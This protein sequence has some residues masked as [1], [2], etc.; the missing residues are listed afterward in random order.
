MQQSRFGGLARLIGL[1]AAALIVMATIALVHVGLTAS[2]EADTQAARSEKALFETFLRG[3]FHLMARDQLSLAQWDKSVEN[4]VLHFNRRYLRTEVFEPLWYD[5]AASFN[6]VVAADGTVVASAKRD[7]VTFATDRHRLDGDAARLRDQAVTLFFA[8]RVAVDGGFRRR[9]VT[10]TEVGEIAAAGFVEIDG[11][12]H[13]AVAMAI[14][15]DDGSVKLPD[16]PP[17]VLLSARPLDRDLVAEFAK[18]LGFRDLAFVAAADAPPTGWVARTGDGRSVGA[19]TW[20]ADTPGARIWRLIVPLI[21]GAVAVLGAAA[22]LVARQIGGLSRRLEASEAHN[23][24]VARHD[25]L[26]GLA[27]RREIEE[28]LAE[29]IA[30]LPDRPFAWIACDLDRFKAVNDTFGHAAGDAVIVAVAD[31]LRRSV[32]RAGSIARIGGDEF[33]VLMTAFCDPPRLAVLC[34][35]ISAAIRAPIALADGVETDVGVSLGIAIAD[36]AGLTGDEICAQADAAL[37]RAKQ[38]GRG[39]AVFAHDRAEIDADPSDAS[40]PATQEGDRAA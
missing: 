32:G 10:T 26:S 27:N 2:R 4:I 20:T 40:A 19:F 28:R 21:L 9:H 3:R 15:P 37:Y 16:G 12:P 31:R 14:V 30:G 34:A 7:E 5:F 22:F 33:V 23:R 24:H 13:V 11:L 25:A 38:R 1:A 39:R 18:D 29:A 35:E 6:A 8:D 36:V 17:M